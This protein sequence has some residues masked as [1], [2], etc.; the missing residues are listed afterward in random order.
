MEI[1][2]EYLKS[3]IGKSYNAK[4]SHEM[5]NFMKEQQSIFYGG[6]NKIPVK[7]TAFV[8]VTSLDKIPEIKSIGASCVNDLYTDNYGKLMASFIRSPSSAQLEIVLTDSAGVNRNVRAYSNSNTY[9]DTNSSVGS[10][11]KLGSGTT[12]PAR[13]DFDVE[14]DLLGA[15]ENAFLN[16]VDGVAGD[17]R[18]VTARTIVSENTETINEVGYYHKIRDNTGTQRTVMFAHDAVSPAVAY[19]PAQAITIEY[20]FNY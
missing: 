1:E 11:F 5:Q 3:L 10:Q 4:S 20:I 19:T 9:N 18:T 15:P 8:Y 14:T 7:E 13:S 12:T 16:T 6:V 17:G 2:N